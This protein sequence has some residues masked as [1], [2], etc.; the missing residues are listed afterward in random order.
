MRSD[1]K[2]RLEEFYKT[3]NEKGIEAFKFLSLVTRKYKPKKVLE[4]GSGFGIGS[5]AFLFDT[6]VEE[7]VT[8]DKIKDLE[9][10]EERVKIIGVKNRVTRIIGDSVETINN[11]IEKWKDNFGMVY[12]DG[13]HQYE[14]V[15]RDLGAVWELNIPIIILDDFFH[16]A[17][18][19]GRYGIP[20][21]YYDF[22]K[23]KDVITNVF[24]D[25]NGYAIVKRKYEK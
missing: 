19:E 7:T 21:A 6:D 12:V 3:L 5:S 9:G 24:T 4:I 13:N 2:Q 17:N 11:N 15:L 18:W 14:G 25:A 8:I 10:F 20:R 22:F 23:E 16:K 1:Q